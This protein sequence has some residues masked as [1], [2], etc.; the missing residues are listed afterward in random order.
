MRIVGSLFLGWLC[1]CSLY[2][3]PPT[4][5]SWSHESE[6]SSPVF[7]PEPSAD[8]IR[9]VLDPFMAPFV[10]EVNQTQ[11]SNDAQLEALLD[12]LQKLRSHLSY[13]WIGGSASPEGSEARN[14]Q[15]GQARADAV[16]HRLVERMSF[17]AHRLWTY[18]RAEDWTSLENLLEQDRHFPNRHRVMEILQTT[19]SAEERKQALQQLDQGATWRHLI[20]DMF[21]SLRLVRVSVALDYPTLSRLAS[22][23]ELLPSEPPSLRPDDIVSI[24]LLPPRAQ[25]TTRTVKRKIA[26]KTNLLFDAL[27]VANL[28]VEISPWTHWSLDIPVWYSPYSIASTWKIRLLGIQPEIRWWFKEAMQGHFIGCHTHVFGFN[29]ALNDYARYQDPNHALWGI[30]LSYGYA[31]SL[32]QSRHWGMEF[33]IGAGFANYRYEAYLPGRNGVKFKS[34]SDRY[35]GITRAGISLIYKW[36]LSPKNRKNNES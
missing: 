27:L 13:V 30:G 21:P 24:P 26:L 18:N 35:W 23:T 12:S 20:E 25:G 34:G 4:V 33:T 5:P 28:G 15:L 32:G 19:Q 1:A 7:P 29:I 2:A 17:P 9:V 11:L 10:F 22:Q 36:D 3:E 14:Q 31:L 8:R 16:A 6:S